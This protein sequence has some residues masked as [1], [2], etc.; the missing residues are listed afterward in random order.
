MTDDRTSRSL[1][2]SF[3]TPTHV[4]RF[5]AS[6]ALRPQTSQTGSPKQSGRFWPESH[7]DGFLVN[8]RKPHELD[9][10]SANQRS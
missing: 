5:E 2:A 1:D 6:D 3:A 7:A 8:H 9:V 4:L 10:A